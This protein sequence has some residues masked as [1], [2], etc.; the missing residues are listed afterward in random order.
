[1]T[2]NT[3]GI[4]WLLGPWRVRAMTTNVVGIIW[5]LGP[6]RVRAMHDSQL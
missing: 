5:L 4:T 2:A 1:M 6:W 3:V